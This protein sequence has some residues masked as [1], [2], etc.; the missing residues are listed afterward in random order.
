M[1]ALTAECAVD[2]TGRRDTH[3][4]VARRLILVKDDTS[5]VVHADKG[6]APQNYMTGK[7]GANK[8]YEEERDGVRHLV[9]VNAQGECLDISLYDVISDVTFDDMDGSIRKPSK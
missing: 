2:F 4:D 9:C 3:S 1:R 7:R 5:V 8:V 6:V